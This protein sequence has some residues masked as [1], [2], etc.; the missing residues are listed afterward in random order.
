M[1]FP[2]PE[3]VLRISHYETR[4]AANCVITDKAFKTQT[5][6]D[7]RKEKNALKRAGDWSGLPVSCQE[8]RAGGRGRGGVSGDHSELCLPGLSVQI[9]RK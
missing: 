7:Q 8:P 1:C 6:K 4:H 5:N 2:L 3:H 9:E